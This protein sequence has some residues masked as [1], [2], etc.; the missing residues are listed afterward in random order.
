MLLWDRKIGINHP[1]PCILGCKFVWPYLLVADLC[2][3]GGVFKGTTTG[4][5]SR[6]FCKAEL[7]NATGRWSKTGQ[8]H[9]AYKTFD[10]CCHL[11]LWFSALSFLSILS[12]RSSLILDCLAGTIL[13]ESS[14][15]PIFKHSG[16]YA[17]CRAV[18]V[19]HWRT[20]KSQ[21]HGN[22]KELKH[23]KESQRWTDLRCGLDLFFLFLW[24]VRSKL[25][26]VSWFIWVAPWGMQLCANVTCSA[27]EVDE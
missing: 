6:H 7:V 11:L 9:L 18:A 5:H 25:F 27:C 4:P 13:H 23:R 2:W 19:P 3:G 8:T 24:Y 14:L 22:P 20:P 16:L 21:L 17:F 12:W 1:T 26:H 15:A 10:S